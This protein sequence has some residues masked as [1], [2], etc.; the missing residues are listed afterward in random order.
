MGQVQMLGKVFE[1]EKSFDPN[2]FSIR[3][4]P[5]REPSREYEITQLKDLICFIYLFFL[6]NKTLF[7]VAL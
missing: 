4:L 3:I 6:S 7:L 2:L 5:M 1:R